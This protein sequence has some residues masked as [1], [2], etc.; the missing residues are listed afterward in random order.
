MHGPYI[1]Q[2]GSV[3]ALACPLQ[4]KSCKKVRSAKGE[5]RIEIPGFFGEMSCVWGLRL[6]REASSSKQRCALLRKHDLQDYKNKHSYENDEL[7]A[8]FL[9]QVNN[10]VSL[11]GIQSGK[12]IQDYDKSFS[13]R[14]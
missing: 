2:G 11:Q 9:E 3:T 7:D 8:L 5:A 12:T 4:E 6:L 14:R 10:R 13:V 1:A